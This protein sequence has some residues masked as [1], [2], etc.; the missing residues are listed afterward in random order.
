MKIISLGV[1]KAACFGTVS[2][3]GIES[4]EAALSHKVGNKVESYPETDSN[5]TKGARGE[6]LQ[7]GILH[8]TY[9][10]FPKLKLQRCFQELS[11]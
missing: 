3:L 5:L 4:E 6:K 2:Y 10:K 1:A 7:L 8:G 11:P 9:S